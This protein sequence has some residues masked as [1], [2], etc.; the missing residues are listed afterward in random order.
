MPV[1]VDE[2]YSDGWWL[3]YL[4]KQLYSPR[5]QPNGLNES[6]FDRFNRLWSYFIGQPPLPAWTA[7]HQEATRQ[8]MKLARSNYA[9]LSVKARLDRQKLQGV[10]TA[11]D[12]DPGGDDSFRRIAQDNGLAAVAQEALT[13][14]HAMS[15]GYVMTG[16]SE[17]E[18]RVV[19]TAEDPR[20]MITDHDPVTG[21]VRAALKLYYDEAAEEHVAHLSLPG[22]VRVATRRSKGAAFSTRFLAR[23]WDWDDDRSGELLADGAEKLVPVARL[24]SRFGLGV[25]EPHLDLLN[26]IIEQ[27]ADRLWISKA[28]AYRQWALEV[29]K[30][31]AENPLPDNDPVTGE[32]IDYD[33]LL[34]R[35]PNSMWRLPKGVTIWESQMGDLQQILSAAKADVLEYAG[36]TFTPLQVLFPDAAAGSAEGASLQRENLTFDVEDSI[37]CD[38]PE[39]MKVARHA[40]ILNGEPDRAEGELR[41][42]WGPV[43]R[44]SLSQRADAAQKAHVSGTPAEIVDTEIW[45]WPP[46]VAERAARLRA[47]AQLVALGA[48]NQVTDG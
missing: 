3:A 13:F 24:Q 15:V 25:Y 42:I 37:D 39:W 43:E 26:R 2:T 40:F 36:V 34:R 23:Q 11:V 33:N 48:A 29:D 30:D 10:R 4:Y 7:E 38:N 27:I 46:D 5:L 41:V 17:T 9:M 21:S 44:L 28:Q 20:Q 18:K 19:I 6:R 8:F 31:A 12:D 32:P 14:K 22:R 47:R 1:D 16:W 45:H 35:D